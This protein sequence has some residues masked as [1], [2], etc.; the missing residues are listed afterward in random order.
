MAR[1]SLTQADKQQIEAHGLTEARVAE[2]VEIFEKGAPYADLVRP[3]TIGDG[4]RQVDD[5]TVDRL[6]RAFEQNGRRREMVKFVPASGAATRMFKALLKIY[7][8]HPE[9]DRD[10]L[11]RLTADR[12]GQYRDVLEFI[13]RI[14]G[15]AFYDALKQRMADDG[16]D[17]EQLRKAGEVHTILACV[18]TERGLGYGQKPK[19]LIQFHRYPQGARTAFEEHLVE[20][21][22][23]V[24]DVRGI[25]RLHFTVSPEH[26]D[27]FTALLARSGKA[28]ENAYSASYD[29]AF[30][31]QHPSTDTIAVDMD[32]QPFRDSDGRLVFRPGGHGA[33]IENINHMGGDIVFIKN[34]DNV[35]PDRLKAETYLWKKVLTGYLLELE[36]RIRGHLRQLET[37]DHGLD[38]GAAETFVENELGV[39]LPPEIK[40]ADLEK[41]R[42]YLIDRL[43]RP[44][45]VCG[46]VPSSGEPGGGPFW[47]KDADGSESIQIVENA[48]IDP[49]SESQQGILK[50]LTHF[51]PVDIVCSLRNGQGQPYDLHRF[52]DKS[53]V[54]ISH[55]SK[56]GR[57]L[58]ALE[59]P[60][61]WNGGMAYWNTVFVEV[62]LITF[63]PVKTVNDLL[64][65]VH[66][67]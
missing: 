41:K 18:L 57:D 33:L 20:A 9:I 28:Y 4:I 55:K 7:N 49:D 37:D 53:A 35:V 19:G 3:C 43:D 16:H 30:S 21:A 42:R 5:D 56:D 23:Y 61:L 13:D 62:P 39:S 31:Q 34:V 32:N 10:T 64:R 27:G 51:N 47:V 11:F 17:L 38:L 48:Q 67:G 66:Q 50:H 63:N 29:V 12:G 65:D 44:L 6:V 2:Q 26:E 1:L 46:M 40:C 60:G 24:K 8:E 58:K 45:R 59:H 14:D 15:F 25:C 52:V 22:E 54:F 36:E